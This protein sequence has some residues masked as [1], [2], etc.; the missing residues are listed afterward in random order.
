M[1]DDAPWVEYEAGAGPGENRHI[2]LIAGD[3]E[4]RSEEALPM[5]AR[6]LSRRHGFRCTV[7]FSQDAE[8]RIDP[9]ARGNIPGLGELETADLMVLFTRFRELPDKDMRW[10]VDYVESGRPFLGIRTATHA[11]NYTEDSDSRYAHW[12]WNH[13]KWKGGFGRHYLG[14]TWVNHHGHHGSEST[15]GVIPPGRENHPILRGVQDVWGPTDV[16]G[17]R[18]LPEDTVVLLE[19]SVRAGMTPDAPEVDDKRNDP[20]M[21]IAWLR[22]RALVETSRKQRIVCTTIGAAPDFAS[23]DLRRLFV[24]AC[25]WLMRIEDKIPER[26]DVTLV[27]EYEPTPFGFGKFVRGR[28]PRDHASSN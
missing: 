7:L 21:P 5:L 27:G 23:E 18:E 3:E 12:G 24:N 4:Y 15:R 10:I 22:E 19:G 28:R 25:Y 8:G 9:D 11:F 20:R 6:I 14:E 1:A 26:G 17:I 2:V 16:Y 13:P